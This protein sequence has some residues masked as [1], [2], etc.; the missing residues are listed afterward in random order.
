MARHGGER[1]GKRSGKAGKTGKAGKAGKAGE[2]AGRRTAGA[3]PVTPEDIARAAERVRGHVLRTPLI[4][5]P[6]LSELT[7]AEIFVKYENMQAT[8]S[9]KDRGALVKLL[10][11]TDAERARGVIAMSAGNHAQSVAWHARRL[12]IPATIVMPQTT[13]FVKVAST[14]ALG[15]RVVLA[16]D[17]LAAA[18]READ[19]IAREEGLTFVHPYDDPH[20]IAGQGTIALEILE[21]RPDIE[22]L[23][24][25]IGGGGLISGIAVAAKAACPDMEIVGVE[26]ALYPSMRAAITG[27]DL[28]AGGQTLAEGI[29]VK[30]AGRLTRVIVEALVD[31]ILLVS[32]EQIECAVAAFLTEQ[33]TMAEGAGAA[34]LAAVMAAPERFSGRRIALVLTGGNIDARVL[35]SI[36]IRSLEREGKILALRLVISDRP[37]MLGRIATLLGESGANILEVSHRRML[38]DVPAK[39]ATLDVTI[40]VKDRAHARAVIRHLEAQGYP[41]TRLPSTGESELS[42]A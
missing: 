13:P 32:E 12:A 18:A 6:R 35:A 36:M 40:E 26:A 17:T 7:G 37:G 25:P 24:V 3:L 10:A 19:R 30:A 31:D 5:A 39:G 1:G 8:G 38:L 28:P 14:E 20:V 16:G 2:S 11:L 42:V 34:G 29:A 33:K 4:R 27:E 22:V 15:A 41:V 23:V 21:A 9:F